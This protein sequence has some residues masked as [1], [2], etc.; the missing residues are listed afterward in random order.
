MIKI[1]LIP[2]ELVPK[3]RNLLPHF[4]VAVLA[5]VLLLWFG[6]SLAASYSQ[7]DQDQK[8]LVL[9]E[10][11]LDSLQEAVAQVKQLEKDKE[12]L[13]Q[14]EQAVVQI[15]TGRTVWSHELYVLAGLVPDGL[16]L[17]RVNMSTRR[18]PVTVEVP[19]PNRN[20]GQPPTIQKTV[21]QSFP[22]IR[23]SGYALSPHREKGLELVGKLINNIKLDDEFSVRFVSPE[24]K[25]IERQE[26]RGSTVMKFVMD[27][28]ISI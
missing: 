24:L 8:R 16:W 13:S 7:L 25:S 2:R 17:E 9:I 28:E 27:C 18:R 4:A 22:A 12:L 15:T 19:N 20:P 5:G 21:V 11:E 3:K 10:E 23:L 6:S 1:N 26:F 14:K